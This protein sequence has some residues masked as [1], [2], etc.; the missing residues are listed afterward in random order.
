MRSLKI[1]ILLFCFLLYFSGCHLLKK[2][3]KT[4]ADDGKIEFVFLQINDVYEIALLEGGKAG[5]LARVATIR[6]DLLLQNRNT[7]TVLAGDFLNPSLIGTV[8]HEGKRIKGKQMV[9]T[10]N[11]LGLDLA[12]FG[13]HEF[14]LKENEL[15]ERLNESTFDWVSKNVKH[16]QGDKLSAFVKYQND[17]TIPIPETYIWD[18]KDAD[19]TTAKVGVVAVTLPFNKKSYVHYDDFTQAAKEAYD[20]LAA[21]CDVV[22]ALTHLDI[23]DDL[24]LAE[25]LPNLKLVMGG[26]DHH[27][28]RHEVGNVVVAKADANAKTVYVHQLKLDKTAKTTNVNSILMTIDDNITEDATTAKVVNKWNMIAERS[29]S[30]LGFEPNKL[31]LDT[32]EVLEGREG[33]IRKQQTNLG[34]IV[35]KS[36]SAA[37]P[38]AAC[39]IVNSG[40]IRVDD[41]LTGKITQFDI[42]RTLPFGGSILEVRMKGD[43]LS[44]VVQIGRTE[45]VGKGGFLQLDK[46][47]WNEKENKAYINDK[48]VDANEYYLVAI[49]SF[50]MT[51]RESN[52]D[53][54]TEEN[55]G[56]KHINRPDKNDKTNKKNDIRLTIIDY[57]QKMKQ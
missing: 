56:V 26:H 11:V 31:V 39:S 55:E 49:S 50:L 47:S 45:N 10:L 13:N 30:D 21:T 19:G 29:Y 35:A 51:G 18:I 42:M 27:N 3:T 20:E 37:Y 43:L 40:S 53:F 24:K 48:E 14:D 57:M 25:Q 41:Q 52:L 6:K 36:I 7:L 2:P 23:A 54:L 9:E 12:A 15:Q 5:G 28:M 17:K 44:K 33:I 46:V 16:K 4:T 8:K 22:V 32:D 38:K 1:N 34:S